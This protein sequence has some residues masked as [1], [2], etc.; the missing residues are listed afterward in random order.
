MLRLTHIFQKTKLPP[1]AIQIL[2]LFLVLLLTGACEVTEQPA[3]QSDIQFGDSIKTS[4]L[5]DQES[6]GAIISLYSG[7][8]KTSDIYADKIWKFS[9]RDSSV[10]LGLQVDF[11]DSSKA[12]TTHLI[13]DSG[14]ILETQR[15]MTAIGNVI[16]TNA[17]SSVLL[18]EELV[19]NGLTELITSD[20]FVTFISDNDTIQGTG[21]RTDRSMRKVKILHQVSG[22]ISNE[23]K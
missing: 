20:S 13:A 4:S 10:V 7:E 15:L 17:D 1:R 23:E 6:E 9:L 2:F 12:I 3:S 5:P 16:V 8:I 18:T 19:W 21:L 22:T 14:V 11:Y